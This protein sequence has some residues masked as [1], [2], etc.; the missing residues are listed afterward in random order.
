M[1][2]VRW[3]PIRDLMGLQEDMDMMFE[4][5]FG[6]GRKMKEMGFRWT[7]RVDIIEE[8]NRY[9][10]T[11]DLPGV[12][13]EDVKVEIRDNVL[14]LRGE[15]KI[16]EEKKNKNYRLSERFYGEF[17]RTFTLP[18]NVNKD[19][20]DAEYRDGVLHLSIPKTEKAKPKQIEVKVK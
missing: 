7:P 1:A 9:E 11:A 13:K 10:V 14:T 17:T 15:K 6:D 18:E 19:A 5:F 16:E 3:N 20:I 4:N 12:N 2:I 8:E